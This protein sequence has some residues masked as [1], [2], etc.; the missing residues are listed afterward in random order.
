M[1]SA[2]RTK[3][4]HIDQKTTQIENKMGFSKLK[5]KNAIQI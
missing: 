2:R 1:Q 5:G 4:W 3:N